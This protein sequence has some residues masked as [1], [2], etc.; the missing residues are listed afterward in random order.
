M[1]LRRYPRLMRACIAEALMVR[2][3]HRRAPGGRLG[4]RQRER[5]DGAERADLRERVLRVMVEHTMPESEREPVEYTQADIDAD[6]ARIRAKAEALAASEAER[7]ERDQAR[8]RSQWRGGG[9]VYDPD[10]VRP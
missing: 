3:D 8:T 10:G 6:I 9:Y 1:D 2:E 5:L 7:E 4:E